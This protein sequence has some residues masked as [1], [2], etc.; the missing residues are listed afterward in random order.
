MEF[1][2]GSTHFSFSAV[3]LHEFGHIFAL[4]TAKGRIPFVRF[5]PFGIQMARS[6]ML[7][8]RQEFWVY[9]GGI[10]ANAAALLATVPFWGWCNF[11]MAN[12]GLLLFQLLPVG[13][14][15]AAE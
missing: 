7:T 10:L 6:G 4:R 8:Y 13:L 15:S 1:N 11:A 14:H 12:L 2:I 9:S 3:I 5:E